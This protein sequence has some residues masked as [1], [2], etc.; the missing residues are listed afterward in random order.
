MKLSIAQKSVGMMHFGDLAENLLADALDA[1][2]SEW[3]LQPVKAHSAV[4]RLSS[5]KRL[6]LVVKW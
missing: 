4:Q 6:S 3:E 1:A 5:F 2:G